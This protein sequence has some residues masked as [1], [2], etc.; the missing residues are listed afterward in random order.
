MALPGPK[1]IQWHVRYRRELTKAPRR[2]LPEVT[3]TGLERV[4]FAVLHNLAHLPKP[5]EPFMR[6]IQR[7]GNALRPLVPST[8]P[9][10]R[11]TFWILVAR[12]A[13]VDRRAAGGDLV[14]QGCETPPNAR[15][16]ASFDRN[17]GEDTR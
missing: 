15:S 1:P 6:R 2:R 4:K 17:E 8:R 7:A 3:P 14:S 5:T 11:V 10:C 12:R 9:P 13:W 16:Q